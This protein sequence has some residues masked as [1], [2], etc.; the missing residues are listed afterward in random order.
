MPAVSQVQRKFMGMVHQCQKTGKCASPKVKK[1]AKS[2]K[3][4]D[5][6]DFAAT[7]HKGL[8]VKKECNKPRKKKLTKEEAMQK[9]R[10]YIRE[11]IKSIIKKQHARR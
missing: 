2:M 1:V 7:K 5:V 6:K 3:K 11:T 8:P 9:L 10:N 4:K